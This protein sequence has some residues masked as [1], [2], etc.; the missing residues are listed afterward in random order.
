MLAKKSRLLAVLIL[1]LALLLTV[2]VAM[3][4]KG[5]PGVPG[6]GGG[7]PPDDKGP[8]DG[9]GGPPA[10]EML[11]VKGCAYFDEDLGVWRLRAPHTDLPYPNCL[12]EAETDWKIDFGPEGYCP[13]PCLTGELITDQLDGTNPVT[14][15]IGKNVIG[16][17]RWSDDGNTILAQT[18]EASPAR[19]EYDFIPLTPAEDTNYGRP[20]EG[21]WMRVFGRAGETDR[22]VLV[23]ELRYPN[24]FGVTSDYKHW[25]WWRTSGQPWAKMWLL[26][27]ASPGEE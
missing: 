9:G 25:Y 11:D 12:P 13:D 17:F 4:A 20:I 26:D 24:T 19:A 22:A 10:G 2:S 15:R 7:G 5:A 16:T 14:I 1:V 18:D 21:K 23:W 3:A 8:P 6:G 27:C